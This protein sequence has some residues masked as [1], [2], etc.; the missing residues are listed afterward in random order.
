MNNPIFVDSYIKT[1]KKI[2]SYNTKLNF[3]ISTINDQS[4]Q[5]I[6]EECL[7]YADE[8]AASIPEMDDNTYVMLICCIIAQKY[9]CGF[10]NSPSPELY[11]RVLTSKFMDEKKLLYFLKIDEALSYMDEAFYTSRKEYI[12]DFT[13]EYDFHQSIN[14]HN[15]VDNFL[16]A[17]VDAIAICP[18][19]EYAYCFLVVEF[20]SM[21][22]GTTFNTTESN[23]FSEYYYKAYSLLDEE[24]FEFLFTGNMDC[25]YPMTRFSYKYK[26]VHNENEL[27]DI[28]R[29]EFHSDLNFYHRT[30]T[31]IDYLSDKKI[32]DGCINIKGAKYKLGIPFIKLIPTEHKSIYLEK[33]FEKENT[34]KNEYNIL[35][36]THSFPNSII[37]R[38]DSYTFHIIN[39]QSFRGFSYYMPKIECASLNSL[40]SINSMA[41]QNL[42]KLIM[43][44]SLNELK[45]HQKLLSIQSQINKLRSEEF[46]ETE[47][48]SFISQVIV[49]YE[50]REG[51]SELKKKIAIKQLEQELGQKTWNRLSNEVQKMLISAEIS[52]TSLAEIDDVDYSPAIIP[53]TKALENILNEY[54]YH[55]GIYQYFCT[56]DLSE[57]K[58]Y[59]K[60]YHWDKQKRRNYPNH[61][62]TMGNFKV[63]FEKYQT[64]A[65]ENLKHI[66]KYN[67]ERKIIIEEIR[68]SLKF[69]HEYRNLVA[70]KDGVSASIM[71][72]CRDK[73]ILE[74][75]AIIKNLFRLI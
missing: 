59:S 10:Y 1:M 34:V 54:I 30:N 65:N 62:L 61:S 15:M 46:S 49:Y 44:H 47:I 69:V 6:Y 38:D 25:S 4:T 70:H 73:I 67:Q 45:T 40:P 53:L 63:M 64:Y 37:Y 31:Y 26:D 11:K 66:L 5:N 32:K 55:K 41:I 36:Y 75:K 7:K 33:Y 14:N 28:R 12:D 50:E 60:L 52:Y 22:A 19:Y 56:N 29:K 72:D 3:S 13:I 51:S 16:T 24:T 21:F 39:H 17:I 43:K 18:Q 23:E 35:P 2:E 58:D 27:D 9:L 42:T 71:K 8:Y 74:H 20:A 57:N 48:D 68:D